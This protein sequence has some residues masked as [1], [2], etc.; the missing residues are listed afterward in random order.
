MNAQLVGDQRAQRTRI[1]LLVTT[2]LVWCA[3][4]LW[5]TFVRDSSAINAWDISV[6][7]G[8][9]ATRVPIVVGIAQAN[10]VLFGTIG[11]VV[12]TL[13][14][15]GLVWLYTHE[16][17]LT[18]RFVVTVVVGWSLVELA[19]LIVHRPRPAL[20]GVT[21]V[22]PLPSSSSYPSGHTAFAAALAV[23]LLCVYVH[24]GAN[25]RTVLVVVAIGVVVAVGTAF[26]R[27]YLGVHHFTDV[28]ASLVLV[29]LAGWTISSWLVP[30][31]PVRNE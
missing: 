3:V 11:A 27:M 25:K 30:R 8:L 31:N 12:M 16:W 7:E 28:T 14:L 19:K 15:A 22:V 5:G 9:A 2:V 10:A 20:T 13:A 29:P 23:A 26:C 6:L 24:A 18:W 1:A 17:G 21:E 4:V